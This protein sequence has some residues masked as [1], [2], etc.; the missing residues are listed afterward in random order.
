MAFGCTLALPRLG[1]TADCIDGGAFDSGESSKSQLAVAD[2]HQFDRYLGRSGHDLDMGNAALLTQLR[3]RPPKLPLRKLAL[4]SP[5]RPPQIPALGRTQIDVVLSFGEGN[6]T[7][8]F[9]CRNCL[10]FGMAAGR[11]QHGPTPAQDIWATWCDF[12]GA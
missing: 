6:A 3:H 4:R 9:H 12:P 5:L 2:C 8:R 1:P 11:A 7:T 10:L